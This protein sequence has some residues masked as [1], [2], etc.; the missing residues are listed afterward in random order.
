MLFLTLA[1]KNIS[2]KKILLVSVL[3]LALACSSVKDTP[4]NTQQ[5]LSDLETI[6]SDAYQGRKTGTKGGEMAR[7]FI[8]K[9]LLSLGVHPPQGMDNYLQ[10][11][12]IKRGDTKI[13]GNNVLAFLK[14]KSDSVMVISAHY[15][16]IGIKNNEVFNGADDNASG[17]AA[18]LS[19]VKYFQQ[20][21]PNYS[22]LFAFFDAEEMGLLGAKAFVA[23]AP[24]ALGKIKMN[25]NMDMI[26]HNDKG[27]LYVAGTFSYPF[28]K[29]YI[30]TTIKDIKIIA[31]HD[32][33]KQGHDDWTNQSDQGAFHAKKIPFLYFGVE[34][35][36]DYHQ[37][38]DEFK[39][40]N[41]PFYLN[42]VSAIQE[43]ILNIDQ[44][45]TIQAIFHDNQLMKKQ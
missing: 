15:D 35:H 31:G 13:I 2:M 6:S 11:F 10:S 18:L 24:L 16:H 38:S 19:Y 32:N 5:V 39:N 7:D 26:S 1:K 41:Q 30:H 42:A 36:K 25:I 45:K 44:N 17:V 3:G 34:D 23:N 40:I 4:I 22:M 43:I 14:G 20:H 33:P 9:R 21:K 27:E 12:E 37:A 29:N 8:V 28:L